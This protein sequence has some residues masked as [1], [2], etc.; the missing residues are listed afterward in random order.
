MPGSEPAPNI[1]NNKN[2]HKFSR[3][4]DFRVIID[5]SHGETSAVIALD[6]K[7]PYALASAEHTHAILEN[8]CLAQSFRESSFPSSGT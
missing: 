8:G 1:L 7:L 5:P 3:T 2:S 4:G 6:K